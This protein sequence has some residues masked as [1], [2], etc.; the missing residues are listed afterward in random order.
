MGYKVLGKERQFI[1]LQLPLYILFL[2]QICIL[3]AV[4]RSTKKKNKVYGLY[5]T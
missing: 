1:S 2:V 5:A 3:F 4:D